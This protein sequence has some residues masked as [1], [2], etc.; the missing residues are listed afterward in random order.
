METKCDFVTALLAI[1]EGGVDFFASCLLH[2]DPHELK[3]CRL[4]NR[5]WDEF[6][7]KEVWGRKKRRLLLKEKLV[8]RWKNSD[9]AAEEFGHV[10]MALNPYL[11]PFEVGVVDSIFC[12]D[13]HVFCGLKSGKVG[14]YCLTTGEWVRDLMPGKVH[15][16][17]FS[18]GTKVGG[19]DLVVAAVMWST[20]V[21]VWS[22]KK[23]MERLFCLDV[24]NYP[25]MGVNCGHDEDWDNHE[26]EEI[27]VVGN[28]VIFL[29]EDTWRRKCSLIVIDKGEHNVWESKTL[30]CLDDHYSASLATEKDWI[31]VARTVSLPKPNNADINL[32]GND[33]FRQDI[34]LPDCQPVGF[35]TKIA[36]K[37][38]FI[39][40]SSGTISSVKV[41][42]LASDNLME[43]PRPVASL[44]KTIQMGG[45]VKKMIFNELLFGFVLAP[46]EDDKQDVVLIEK[47]ALLDASTPSE[48]TK[49]R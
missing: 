28:K 37:L 12:N 10:T 43:D 35:Y 24:L 33:S 23:E 38:P 15:A 42:Q 29:R 34:S 14:V 7:R 36:L 6:I 30:A 9:L 48:E 27:Q 41:F 25:C 44:V 22:G 18:N 47:K 11:E 5:A 49:K 46:G 19:S 20:I 31:A 32:W 45:E 21:T 4:V 13:S 26:V 17:H 1:G 3:T 40:V 39:V 16:D 8:E 2:L